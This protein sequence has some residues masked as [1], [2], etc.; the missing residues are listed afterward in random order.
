MSFRRGVVSAAMLAAAMLAAALP[1]AVHAQQRG[2]GSQPVSVKLLPPTPAVNR[3]LRFVVNQPAYIAAFIVAPGEGVRMIYPLTSEEQQQWAGLHDEPLVGLHFDDDAYDVVFGRSPWSAASF[4]VGYAQG[5]RYLYVIASRWPL[6]VTRF[7]HRPSALQRTVGYASARS[8]NGEDALAA[9]LD[10][11][12]SLGSDE[13]WD[14]DVYMLWAP[15]WLDSAPHSFQEALQRNMG[16]RAVACRD[17]SSRIVPLNYWFNGCPGD[18]RLL[19]VRPVQPSIQR[20]AAE[21]ESPTVLPTIRG[22]RVARAPAASAEPV[23]NG[24]LMTAAGGVTTNGVRLPDSEDAPIGVQTITLVR[25]VPVLVAQHRESLLEHEE[26]GGGQGARPGHD[27]FW[28]RGAAHEQVMG[29]PVL[30]PAPRLAPDPALAPAPRMA[31][32][33]MVHSEPMRAGTVHAAESV[34]HAAPAAASGQS[35]R[36][37]GKIQ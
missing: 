16:T 27:R 4:G 11:V 22:V 36:T 2:R 8:F 15:A 26:G 30:A 19:L 1:G 31:P 6:D 21:S 5:P 20:L 13:S 32:A 28:D 25:G 14:A 9:L 33:P 18:A 12:V 29:A 10:N 34:S 35:S 37:A 3:P 23:A 17:G 24:F 7:V